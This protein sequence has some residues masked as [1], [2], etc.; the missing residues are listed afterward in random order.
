LTSDRTS[1]PSCVLLDANVVITAHELGVWDW[2]V[3]VF[4]VSVPSVVVRSEAL[5]YCP[6]SQPGLKVRIDLAAQVMSGRIQQLEGSVKDISQLLEVFDPSF[7]DSIHA[8]E[9]EG[10]ALVANGK[11][12]DAQY[13]SGDALAIQAL[14]ML[15]FAG[16]AVSFEVLLGGKK[17]GVPLE[18]QC[19]EDYLRRNLAIGLEKR[20]TGSGLLK[21][22][23]D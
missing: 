15:G 12:G 6:V 16:R 3:R 1:R 7:V 13:C 2:L 18:A 21:G 19:T 9:A 17:T 10:L 14:A 23:L 4:R 5:H 8:G 20:I 22:L 11:A